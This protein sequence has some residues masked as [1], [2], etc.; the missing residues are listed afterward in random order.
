[1]VDILLS[2]KGPQ[3]TAHQPSATDCVRLQGADLSISFPC[4][5]LLPLLLLLSLQIRPVVSWRVTRA[6][7]PAKCVVCLPSDSADIKQ[8][9]IALEVGPKVDLSIDTIRYSD[10]QT[11][12]G[13]FDCDLRLTIA[14]LSR[15]SSAISNRQKN[16]VEIAAIASRNRSQLQSTTSTNLGL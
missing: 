7:L 4:P 11:L 10:A 5:F 3:A 9:G 12:R 2:A 1:M 15:K 16:S 13:A 6:D 8:E 14:D